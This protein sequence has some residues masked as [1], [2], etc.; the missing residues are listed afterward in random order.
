MRQILFRIWLDRPWAGWTDVPNDLPHLGV[1]WVILFVAATY[2]AVFWLLGKRDLLREPGTWL[3]WGIALILFSLLGGKGWLPASVPVFGY[4]MMVLLGFISGIWFSWTR[5]RSVGRDPELIL[6]LSTWLL[7]FGIAGGRLAYLVQY[8]DHAFR[9]VQN[10]PQALFAIVNLSEG[11]L[12][13]IGGLA[14]G[15]LGFV[16]FCW[17]RQQD[18]FDLADLIIPAVFLGI[19][20]GRLGCLLNGC[21]F[22]D[23][24]ELPWGITFPQGSVTF[25]ILV[26]RGFLDPGAARTI[27]LHPTQIYSALDGFILFIV[28]A[29]FYWHRRSRGSVFGLGCLLYSLTRFQIEFLRADEMGQLGTGLTISQIYCLGILVLGLTLMATA[30]W[31]PLSERR[32]IPAKV[33]GDSL[34]LT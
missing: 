34:P 25:Q 6:D 28:T 3:T 31:R 19:G 23:R 2:A 10:L 33:P 24:C 7:L 22:G 18:P 5:A 14:G 13:L 9:G 21:C 20:F 12:V 16:L 32:A 27:P 11:G 8:A 1:C 15:L 29:T 4:G 30:G 26:E 17:K